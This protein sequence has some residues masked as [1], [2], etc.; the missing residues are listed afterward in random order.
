MKTTA[1]TMSIRNNDPKGPVKIES[2]TVSIALP[3]TRQAIS[4]I[5]RLLS[6]ILV[7]DFAKRKSE[8]NALR[9]PEAADQF[10]ALANAE[11]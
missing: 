2:S 9:F 7:P 3:D 4:I 6:K 10:L 5:E 11:C 8:N 1:S